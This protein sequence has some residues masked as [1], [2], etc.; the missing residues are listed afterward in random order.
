M[1][2]LR[3]ETAGEIIRPG[4]IGAA[5]GVLHITGA[6]E[7]LVG[8]MLA[9]IEK[10]ADR[11]VAATDHIDRLAGSVTGHVVARIR[12]LRVMREIEPVP[13]EDAAL[14]GA[15]NLRVE[16]EFRL[17]CEAFGWI[18]GETIANKMDVEASAA[19]LAKFK[20]R[21]KTVDVIETSCLSGDGLGR[22]KKDQGGGNLANSEAGEEEE[23]DYVR[24]IREM[25]EGT[26]D[27]IILLDRDKRIKF[28]GAILGVF[29]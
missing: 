4:M 3:D 10:A 17:G 21:H 25:D 9:H 26:S 29:N 22:L 14:L 16:V 28:V 1:S 20:K 18:F 8:A 5:N 23:A 24:A 11:S 13:A 2:A 15:E 12:Q 19:L 7:Q 27:G 6:A